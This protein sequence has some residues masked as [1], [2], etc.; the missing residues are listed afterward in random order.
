MTNL[1]R[2]A[3]EASFA[4]EGKR[5]LRVECPAFGRDAVAGLLRAPNNVDSRLSCVF[6]ELPHCVSPTPLVPPTKT[7]TRPAG[8]VDLTR[9]LE[10]ST[11]SRETIL[12][13]QILVRLSCTS[14]VELI[15]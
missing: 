14:E 6:R 9:P 7:A 12:V 5:C 1:V 10:D 3:H 13:L 4:F 8:R 11:S 2:V 15:L